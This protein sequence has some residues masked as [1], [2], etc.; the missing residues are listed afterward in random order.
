MGWFFVFLAAINELIGVWGLNLFS[1]HHTLKS[2]AFYLGGLGL[3]FAFIYQSFSYLPIT[4]AYAVWTGISTACVVLM[5]MIFFGESKS[6][7][8]LASLGAIIIG[9]TG[10]R[11][12]S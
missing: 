6:W 1:K 10:L 5:N 9:V 2:G 7:K 8:R 3:S 4:V 12:L 11:L